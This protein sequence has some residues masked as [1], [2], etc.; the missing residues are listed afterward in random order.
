MAETTRMETTEFAEGISVAQAVN[1][2]GLTLTI[3]LRNTADWIL[4]WGLSRRPGGAWERPPQSC[5]PEGTA[6][7]DASAVRTQFSG[8]GRKEV[9][10]HL[11]SSSP[12]R[13]LAFVVYS[14]RENRWIKNAGRDFLVTLPRANGNSPEEALSAL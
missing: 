13:G 5:W 6:P 12:W 1:G 8:H 3:T 11:N 2:S 4:H 9:T 14:P 10:I 7:A